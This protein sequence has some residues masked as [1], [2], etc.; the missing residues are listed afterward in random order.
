MKHI[1]TQISPT[2]GKH[3]EDNPPKDY[4]YHY[5]SGTGLIGILSGKKVRMGATDYLNDQQ[6]MKH[7]FRVVQRVAQRMVE[8]ADDMRNSVDVLEKIVADPLDNLPLCYVASFT[9]HSDQLSQWRAYCPDSGGYAI[10]IPARYLDNLVEEMFKGRFVDTPY[11]KFIEERAQ[12]D[13]RENLNSKYIFIKCIYEPD[14]QER[15]AEETLKF[16][17]S[18]SD[19]IYVPDEDSSDDNATAAYKNI[20]RLLSRISTIFKYPSFAEEAEWRII[21]P[22]FVPHDLLGFVETKQGLKMYADFD[23]NPTEDGLKHATSEEN[24]HVK[25]VCGPTPNM[26]ASKRA[27]ERLLVSNGLFHRSTVSYQTDKIPCVVNS[28][29]PYKTW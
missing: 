18:N 14:L 22:L 29:V 28:S 12:K 1:L 24:T 17:M 3:L 25:V 16:A 19:V 5:T 13:M 21:S 2:L 6:E 9:E 10:G 4:L 11:G 15:I 7:F 20:M 27:A 26:K 8:Q 23:L